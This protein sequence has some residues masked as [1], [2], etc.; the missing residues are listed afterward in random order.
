MTT[1]PLSL[2][3]YTDAAVPPGLTYHYQ[4]TGLTDAYL[5]GNSLPRTVESLPSETASATAGV[6]G[7]AVRPARAAAGKTVKI[8]LAIANPFAIAGAGLQLKLAYDPAL[9]VPISQINPH[10]AAV[11]PSAIAR[12]LVFT[13]NAAS[14]SGELIITGSGGALNLGEGTLFVLSFRVAPGAPADATSTVTL[15]H[16]A[17]RD[18]AGRALAW[19]CAQNG[20][21]TVSGDYAEGDLTGDGVV[22]KDDQHLLTDLLKLDA[23]PPT[24]DELS[25]G[26][27]N[28]DG[29]LD[30]DDFVL[31]K[32]LLNGRPLE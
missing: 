20:V 30:Q 25:A 10:Q 4:V 19:E 21:L 17:A 11:S 2:P 8:R 6:I 27:L 1:A 22:D 14:A 32:R 15:T 24:A 31:L 26:D 5:P 18:T 9:L 29:L 28:A 7:F 3:A 12:D 23:R 16:V 13:D